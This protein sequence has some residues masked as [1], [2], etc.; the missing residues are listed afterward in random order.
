METR[1]IDIR[2]YWPPVVRDME[3][4]Q[5][6]AAAVNPELNR[7]VQCIYRVLQD[8]FVLDATENGVSRWESSCGIVPAAGATLDERK[9][10]I[11]IYL[12]TKLPYT[13]RV[14]KQMLTSI[15]GSDDFDMDYINDE[16]KLM[17]RT[18]NISEDKLQTIKVLLGNV[19]PKNIEVLHH[20]T[21]EVTE[22]E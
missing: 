4:F 2:T 15:I 20:N 6:I 1:E 13:W 16:G 22:N 18:D 12:S 21:K 7:L 10:A 17:L 8:A 14:V 11:L 9:A 19:L 5:Q 3:E